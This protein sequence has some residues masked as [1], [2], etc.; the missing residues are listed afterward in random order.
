MKTDRR[1]EKFWSKIEELEKIEPEIA[2]ELRKG[3]KVTIV[4]DSERNLD[5][6]EYP[7]DSN[8]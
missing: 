2:L 5:L 8:Y 6:P 3:N 7:S 4:E 1:K